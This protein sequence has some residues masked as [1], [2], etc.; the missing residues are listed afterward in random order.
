MANKHDSYADLKWRIEHDRYTQGQFTEI[1]PDAG[2]V[3]EGAHLD[4]RPA[5]FRRPPLPELRANHPIL[6][7]RPCWSKLPTS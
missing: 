2:F 5:T 6:F 1:S 7:C 4:V 3:C